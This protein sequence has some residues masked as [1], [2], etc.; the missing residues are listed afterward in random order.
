MEL[1]DQLN[2]KIS[3]D[4]TPVRIVSLVPSQTELLVDLGLEHKIVGVTNFCVHPSTIRKDKVVVGGTKSLHYDRIKELNPDIILCNKEENTQEIVEVLS[5]EYTL[6]ISD[7]NSM[8]DNYEMIQQYGKLFGVEE[9]A[10]EIC[11]NI[12]SEV[13]Q[14]EEFISDKPT[15]KVAYFIWRKPW[16]VVGENTFINHL[17]ELNKF[18]NVYSSQSRYPEVELE[19]LK[20]ADF[21]LLSSE[22][23]PFKEIHKI[24]IQEVVENAKFCFVDGEYFSWYGSRMQKAFQYF[25]ELREEMQ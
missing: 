6:H 13:A 2:R 11:K 15:L 22:P 12:Q 7:V 14:F 21:Y 20:S 16:M 8:A 9:R 17:I 23:F 10:S 3:I 4:K 24:E 1:L 5:K 25:R 19:S 18:E